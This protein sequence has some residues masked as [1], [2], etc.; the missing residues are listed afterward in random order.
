MQIKKGDIVCFKRI[1][2][3][4]IDDLI[5][6]QTYSKYM[7]V[8]EVLNHVKPACKVMCANGEINW[9]AVARLRKAK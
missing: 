9:V 1:Y 5:R 3:I 8:I 4:G 2:T 7:I 6:Q